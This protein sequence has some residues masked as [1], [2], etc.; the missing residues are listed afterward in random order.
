MFDNDK[1]L[2]A[3]LQLKGEFENLHID[4]ECSVEDDTQKIILSKINENYDEHEA[5]P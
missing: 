5:Q 2:D 4:I 1:Q 3:F